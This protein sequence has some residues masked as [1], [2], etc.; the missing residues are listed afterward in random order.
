MGGHHCRPLCVVDVV[1]QGGDHHGLVQ[2]HIFLFHQLSKGH[3][4]AF[5]DFMLSKQVVQGADLVDV[6][7]SD[8]CVSCNCA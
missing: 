1:R 6:E 2:A 7:A 4:F 5:N 8:T 3:H